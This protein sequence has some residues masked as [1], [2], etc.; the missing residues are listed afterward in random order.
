MKREEFVGAGILGICVL[1][2]V[3]GIYIILTQPTVPTP[4]FGLMEGVGV[5]RIYGPIRTED[6]GIIFGKGVERTL[7]VMK[8]MEKDPRIKAV[9]LRINSPGGS[10]AAAQELYQAVKRLRRSGRPVVASMG[11]IATSGAYY[12]ACGANRIVANPGTITGN[13]G[14]IMAIPN[15]KELLGKF[16]MRFEVIKGGKHKDIG[17]IFK[18]MSKEERSLLESVVTNAYDQFYDAVLSSRGLDDERLKVIADGRIFTGAQAKEAGLVDE[19]GGLEDAIRIA[20]RLGGIKGEPRV[21]YEEEIMPFWMLIEDFGTNLL[22]SP[23]DK[24]Y[25]WEGFRLEYRYVYEAGLE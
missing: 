11:D 12:V 14:V 6:R 15:V 17:A 9:V 22:K 7:K 2:M 13:I 10:V 20:A 19:V 21:Y 8:R 23:L 5:V 3:A 1:A 18:D 16:G 4:G 25:Q 24:I